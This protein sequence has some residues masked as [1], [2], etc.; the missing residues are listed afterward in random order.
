MNDLRTDLRASPKAARIAEPERCA[1]GPL[2]QSRLRHGSVQICANSGA[3]V[4][5]RSAVVSARLELRLVAKD[6][7]KLIRQLSL[8]SYLMA[9]RRPVTAPEI[10]RDVEGYSVLNEHAF[11]RR[12]YADRSE[13]E[14]L[15]IVLTVEQP[16]DRQD[17]QQ[18]YSLTPEH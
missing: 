17:G 5:T 11:A 13:L 7:E 1:T 10:R 14:S 12:F 8:I 4:P 15:G 16:V 9:E 18:T 6:T 2:P 3:R